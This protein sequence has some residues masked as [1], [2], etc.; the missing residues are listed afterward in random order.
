MSKPNAKVST[1]P[2]TPSAPTTCESSRDAASQRGRVQNYGRGTY[3]A[4]PRPL[5]GSSA[6]WSPFLFV[7][8]SLALVLFFAERPRDGLFG[9]IRCDQIDGRKI[10]SIAAGIAGQQR[11]VFG[12][13]MGADEEIGE[14][15]GANT[16]RTAILHER[17]ARQKQRQPGNRR[18]CNTGPHQRRFEVLDRGVAG[19]RLS[20]D[21]VVDQER[22]SEGGFLQPGQRPIQPFR[23]FGEHVQQNV[24]IHQRH[25]SSPR[26]SAM[27]SSVE[28]PGPAIPTHLA[29]RLGGRAPSAFSMTMLPSS[30]RRNAT[31]LPG[32]IP[33]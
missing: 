11:Q 28:G 6:S 1:S 9:R 13:R 22:P 17:L 7:S 19:R 14:Y 15:A 27:S 24:R 29:K 8:F 32:P 4:M 30:A 20:V 21:D 5:R 26:S 33:R 12:C 16:A 3:P 2:S 23:I 31:W 18:N 10:S 25:R